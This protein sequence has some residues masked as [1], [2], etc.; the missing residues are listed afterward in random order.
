M[1]NDPD[2]FL[3]YKWY[4][5]RSRRRLPKTYSNQA[6]KQLIV[7]S[8][9][10][11]APEY[12]SVNIQFNRR[13]R[14][15]GSPSVTRNRRLHLH[16]VRIRKTGRISSRTMPQFPLFGLSSPNK[17]GTHSPSSSIKNSV[18]IVWTYTR[19]RIHATNA[20]GSGTIQS[21]YARSLSRTYPMPAPM[22]GMLLARA[23]AI[24]F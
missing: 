6:L 23:A 11:I 13:I 10:I 3:F 12:Y 1:K 15:Y 22:I 18:P 20:C 14:R 9:T 17:T 7:K 16:G 5:G 2:N 21:K 4:R 24:S 19:S 8:V